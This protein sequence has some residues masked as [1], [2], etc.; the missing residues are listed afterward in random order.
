MVVVV[1]GGGASCGASMH[2]CS[3]DVP[4]RRRDGNPHKANFILQGCPRR[5]LP[6]LLRHMLCGA[7]RQPALPKAKLWRHHNPPPPACKPEREASQ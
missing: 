6:P 7:Q 3:C 4:S 5:H 2:V 1:V